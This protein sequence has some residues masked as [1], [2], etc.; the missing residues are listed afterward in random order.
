[1]ANT[2]IFSWNVNGIRSVCQKGFLKWFD[3][4]APCI[5]CLQEI[6]ADEEDI[7]REIRSI[8]G[9]YCYWFPAEKKGYSGT[10]IISKEKPLKIKQGLGV[11]KFD[12]QG[13]TTIAT[14]PN[15]TL[16][17]LYFPHGQRDKEKIPFKKEMYEILFGC[18]KKIKKPVILIGDFNIAHTEKDLA[19]PKENKNNTMVTIE[20]RELLDEV[21]NENFVD[22]F[23]HFN[24]EKK[25]YSWWPYF[26]NARER[27]IGW[28]IDYVFVSKGLLKKV[29]K[30]FILPEVKGSDHCPVGIELE[31]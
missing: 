6:K 5:V 24:K 27:N 26:R 22:T 17:N 14:F 28:R 1:M 12:S 25:E 30:A 21:E 7:P 31:L 29:K 9:Y 10:G 18:L 2:S 20:E 4:A 23:R 8:P 19:R 3:E 16:F 11:E 15:F 13:R